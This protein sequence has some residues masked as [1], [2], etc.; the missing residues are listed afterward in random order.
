MIQFIFHTALYERGESYLAAEAALLKKKKQ[1][2]D[3]LAQLPDRPDPL[4]ARIVAMLRRRIAG[5]EDFVRC[6]AFFDQTEAETAPTV[7]GEPV[8]E[9]VAA[10]LLQDFGPRVAPLLGI[11]LIKLEEIWPFWKTAGSLLY[12]GK[13]APHQASPYLLEFFVGGISAQFRSLAREGLLARADAE[14]IARVDEHLAL[15]ENKSAAL[16]QLAQDLRARPS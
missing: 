13:L 2:A 6:L 5:D 9:W 8:P 16:R 14:L 1:A 15:I 4:E 11:Y 12:L 3:F 7:Q 10:K